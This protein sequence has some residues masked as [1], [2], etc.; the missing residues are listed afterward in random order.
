MVTRLNAKV[1]VT[2]TTEPA[3]CLWGLSGHR[4]SA[5]PEAMERELREQAEGA[6]G[7]QYWPNMPGAEGK[8]TA[9]KTN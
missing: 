9:K 3:V 6:T 7:R 5:K 2:G 4:A 8:D 1:L